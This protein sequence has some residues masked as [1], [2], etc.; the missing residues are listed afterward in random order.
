MAIIKIEKLCKKFDDDVVFD[1]FSLEVEKGDY[2]CITGK[3]GA[4]KSTLLNIIGLLEAPDSGSIEIN[5][6]KN[7]KFQS[8]A[9]TKLLREHISYLFQNYG[10]VETDSVEE[11]LKIGTKYL[12]LKSGEEKEKI[13]QALEFVGLS[14]CEKKKAY[15]LSGGEQQRVAL[16]RI[17]LKPSEIILAD[18]PTG[19]L[20][21][22]N[23]AT[24]LSL[25][26][27][28][29]ESGKTIVVV[30]HSDEVK[31]SAK[32]CINI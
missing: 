28:L 17:L 10:L 30:T 3:S 15:K 9:G 4:G 26:K 6:I 8:A 29:N 31:Q 13:K 12:K 25:L 20:D 21:K 19:S 7:P 16:A 1:N 22:E 27:K 23:Q 24:V 32:K 2:V 14:G 11:N 18:E 5:G